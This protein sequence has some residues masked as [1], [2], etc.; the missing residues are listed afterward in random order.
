MIALPFIVAAV[1]ISSSIAKAANRGRAERG[2]AEVIRS[3]RFAP[4]VATASIVGEWG[5]AASV[6]LWPG[7]VIVRGS[8]IFLFTVFAALGAFAL[9]TG[10]RINCGCFGSLHAGGRLGWAQIL[11]LL[12]VTPV[13]LLL[14]P[15]GWPVTV[16][17][18]AIFVVHLAV[19]AA[20]ILLTIP[21]W[22]EVRLQR[23][24]LGAVRK[25][26]RMT[27]WEELARV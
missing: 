10:R 6:L 1:L 8:L 23:Q 5:V 27:D 17:L 14:F 9:V 13:A 16:G 15:S 12:V 3:E 26:A 4:T 19:G 21:V 24:S 25:V 22:R 20:F 18:T 11:Q 2:I 7:S